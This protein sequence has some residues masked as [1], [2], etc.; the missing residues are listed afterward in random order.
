MVLAG[1]PCSELL[2]VSGENVLFQGIKRVRLA[3]SRLKNKNAQQSA[4][5]NVSAKQSVVRE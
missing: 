2:E 1:S 4:I 3:S 5:L